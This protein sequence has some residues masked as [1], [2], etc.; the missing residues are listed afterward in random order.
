M[1]GQI[2]IHFSSSLLINMFMLQQQQNQYLQIDPTTGDD[3]ERCSNE[4]EKAQLDWNRL[5]RWMS[6]SQSH[7]R[8]REN[9]YMTLATTATST[10]TTDNMSEEKT[11]E[12]DMVLPRGSIHTNMG[13]T[14]QDFL[15]SSPTSNWHYHRQQSGGVVPSY[16]APTQSARA[17]VRRSQGPFKQR[18]FAGPQWNSSTRTYAVGPG[19]DS[20]SSGGT[21][22]AHQF[23]RSPSPKINGIRLQS[24]R[25]LG[26]S[27]YN[28]GT[29]DW[30][31][32]LRAQGWM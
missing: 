14:D 17:K 32:P 28:V 15:V 19:C 2:E 23:S 11:L 18:A 7:V 3:I 30:I 4:R 9:P 6:S 25:I 10:T 21:T 27:P 20:S 24:R 8:Q 26:G 16:M 22:A 29:E 5:E 12:I 31:S 13:L 1:W